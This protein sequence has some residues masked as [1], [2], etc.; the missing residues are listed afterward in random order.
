MDD[1]CCCHQSCQVDCNRATCPEPSHQVWWVRLISEPQMLFCTRPSGSLYM[2]I[3]IGMA[4]LDLPLDNAVATTDFSQGL[5]FVPLPFRNK[6][7]ESTPRSP[8]KRPIARTAH[9]RIL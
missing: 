7:R 5:G 6:L 8:P 2:S 4:R 3:K 9:C 1:P